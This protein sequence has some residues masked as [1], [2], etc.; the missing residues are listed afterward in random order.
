[1]R[2]AGRR[3]D[4]A[5]VIHLERDQMS[6]TLA[7]TAAVWGVLMAL[8]PLLQ[9]RRMVERR[10]SADFSLSF[11]LVLMVGFT[12]WVA[13]GISIANLALIVPN[14]IAFLIGALTLAVALRFRSGPGSV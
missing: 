11:V 9:I 7:V 6:D 4:A 1:M 8:A 3:I 12:L 10:S 13:Y 5:P 2:D 14:A